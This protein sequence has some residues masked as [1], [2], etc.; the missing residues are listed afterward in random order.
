M[1]VDTAFR[2]QSSGEAKF[3]GLVK[4]VGA[5]LGHRPIMV[6]LGLCVPVRVWSDSSAAL[7][8]STKSGLG[9]LRHLETHALWVQEKARTG[10]ILVQKVRGDVNPADLFTKHLLTNIKIDQL[11][12]LFGCENC[13]GRSPAAPMLRPQE[14]TGGEG[15]QPS[16]GYAPA[17]EV[18]EAGMHDPKVLPHMH[19]SRALEKLL[20][21]LEAAPPGDNMEDQDPFHAD[22]LLDEFRVLGRRGGHAHER[23]P[24]RPPGSSHDWV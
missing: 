11:A 21:L 1:V 17:F 22:G 2:H 19:E 10:A 7:G 3:Y 15:G 13:E 5:G 4:A 12:K 9:Q 14:A 18:R 6:D 24:L 8:I 23:A 20:L 16:S